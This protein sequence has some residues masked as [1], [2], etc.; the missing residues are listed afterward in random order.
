MF[1]GPN[2][3]GKSTL[4][5]AINPAWLGVIIDPDKINQQLSSHGWLAFED[6]RLLS[7]EK[8]IADFFRESTLLRNARISMDD[9]GF[10][11]ASNRIQIEPQFMNAY[12]ASVLADFLRSGLLQIRESFTF[13]TV[14]SDPSKVQ[15]LKRAHE[16]GYRTYLYYIATDDPSINTARMH[17]RV[18]FGGHSVPEQKI[19]S[20]YY[21]S[22]DLLP[23]ALH[24]T[25][26]AYI[27]DNSGENT[28][29]TWLAEITDGTVLQMKTDRMPAW[30]KKYVWDPFESLG[31]HA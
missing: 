6:F 10:T 20:R 18:A 29:H 2:G 23:D 26:R 21:R 1:A 16:L 22:L 31:E 4:I 8:T 14:M 11:F 27:F 30:F 15:F 25:D 13:E 24:H 7:T 17:S 3:S 19:F 12:V 5:S 28:D 9:N